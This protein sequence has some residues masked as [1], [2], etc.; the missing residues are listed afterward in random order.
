MLV[1]PNGITNQPPIPGQLVGFNVLAND[2]DNPDAPAQ[3]KAMSF[4]GRPQ[5]YLNPGAWATVQMDPPPVPYS[6]TLK[7]A[8]E[9]DRKL[10]ISWSA[11]ASGYVLQQTTALPG[12]WTAAGLPV[13]TQ[14]E[15]NYVTIQPQVATTF[16]RLA[17]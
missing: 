5:A 3:E 4:T 7:I 2:G 16:Y 11:Q 9:A 8:R 14:G 12:A 17:Q 10:R 13:M 15:E 1:G 6:P